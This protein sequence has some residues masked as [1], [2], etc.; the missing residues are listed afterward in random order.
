MFEAACAVVTGAA[1]GIG[2]GLA[3]R[4]ARRGVEVWALDVDDRGLA[5]LGRDAARASLAIEVRRADVVSTAQ[6]S[7]VRDEI[8]ARRAAIDYWVNNAGI[9]GRG[10]FLGFDEAA[11]NHILSVDLTGVIN[12]TRVALQAMT[13]AGRGTVVNVG[14]VAGHV[15]VPYLSAY[16]AAK[17]GVTGFTRALREEL[18]LQKSPVR[19][20]LVSP[21]FV[22]TRLLEEN[23]SEGF[24]PWLSFLVTKPSVVAAAIVDGLTHGAE[25]INPGLSGRLMQT[26]YRLAPMQTVHS[27]R[28][29]LARDLKDALQGRYEP[30]AHSSHIL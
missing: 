12:G 13:Q 22:E 18:R 6:L 30:P 11:F 7:A 26:A 23:E 4:L 20:V 1:A 2:R 24:P 28:L 5:R 3:L 8:L 29:L 15:P 19:I 27:A 9:G 17:F 25:E 21:G 16:N 10:D 14:S